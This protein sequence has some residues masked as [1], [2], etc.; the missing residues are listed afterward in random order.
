MC[1]PLLQR[2]RNLFDTDFN[3]F[4]VLCILEWVPKWKLT[5]Q[6]LLETF[7]L[8][9]LNVSLLRLNITKSFLRLINTWRVKR[10]S[11]NSLAYFELYFLPARVTISRT[12]IINKDVGDLISYITEGRDHFYNSR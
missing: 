12:F 7:N 9:T 2:T 1:L 4:W 8:D 11:G 10:L 5:F 3:M 6:T